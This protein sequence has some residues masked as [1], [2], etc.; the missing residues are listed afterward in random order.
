MMQAGKACV[1]FCYLL[2][3]G[4]TTQQ[5][6]AL[7]P[8]GANSRFSVHMCNTTCDSWSLERCILDGFDSAF[9]KFKAL[10]V[11]NFSFNGV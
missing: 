11:T 10:T 4:M 3:N 2:G 8:D 6:L 9:T 7:K 1:G 5:E